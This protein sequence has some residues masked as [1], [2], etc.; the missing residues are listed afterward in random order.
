MDRAYPSIIGN[1]D[2]TSVIDDRA[3]DRVTGYVKEAR[4]AGCRIIMSNPGEES[5]PDPVTRKIPLTMIVNPGENLRV[6]QEEVFGPVLSIYTYTDLADAISFINRK[7]KPLALYIFGRNRKSIDK[8]I[9]NTSSGGVTVNDL[10]MHADSDHMGFGGVGYSG[11]GRY[12]G[13]FVGYQAFT[14]PKAVHEQGLMRK[15][16]TMFFKPPST[17]RT[18]RMIRGQVGVK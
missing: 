1:D 9:N 11:M 12:K 2:F 10:L 5:V 4:E 15:F 3:Y 8:V 13:G 14:N 18:R 17:D 16:T 6:S 7:E